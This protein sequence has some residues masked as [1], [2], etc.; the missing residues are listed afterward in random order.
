MSQGNKS[1]RTDKQQQEAETIE[2][3]VEEKVAGTKTAEARL[4]AAANKLT[5][6]SEERSEG[7]KD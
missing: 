6:E 3:G 7:N 2:A 1:S 5:H 4:W